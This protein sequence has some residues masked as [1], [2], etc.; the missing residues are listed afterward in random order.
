MI[1][2]AF[3]LV[4]AISIG[5]PR[6]AVATAIFQEDFE[7]LALGPLT[8]QGPWQAD[9]MGQPSGLMVS[10]SIKAGAGQGAAG[11]LVSGPEAEA[12]S[13]ILGTTLTTELIRYETDLIRT[14]STGEGPQ[15]IL[16]DSGEGVR[17]LLSRTV[18][19]NRT[20]VV[21]G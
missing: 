11:A 19:S 4:M 8:G 16:Y 15:I 18:V 7:A 14:V 2:L 9:F 1:S 12:N 20:P 17:C 5:S 6:A 13:V 3:A 21:L 10:A